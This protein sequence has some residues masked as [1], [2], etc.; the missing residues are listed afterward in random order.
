MSNTIR[1]I[2]IYGKG[3]I[4]KSTLS[5]NLT[6][7]FSQL[8]LQPAQIGCDPKADSVNTLMGGNF[9]STIS[10]IVREHGNSEE[11]IYKAIYRGFNDIV[12]IESGGPI[13]GQ[14]CAGRGVLVALNLI[15]Q[16]K[17]LEKLDID[18]AVYDVL[19]DI[20]CGGFAQPIRQGYAQ[21]VYIVT[22]GEYMALYAANN[23]AV[24][25]K[26]FA[27]QGL[28][29]R[30]AGIISNLRNVQYEKEII[31]EFAQLID[32]PIIHHIPRS[33]YVQKSELIGQTVIEAY[34]ESEQAKNYFE[35]A[36]KI[37]NNQER[38]IPNALSKQELLDLMKRYSNIDLNTV[39]HTI[40]SL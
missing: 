14:G 17:I 35:L 19:G 6:A 32:V 22:S 15:E 26:L 11:S 7:S 5:S 4:G 3:G 39:R 33:D 36:N 38:L 28:K 10:E 27:E 12:C 30:V 25:I 1:Q 37:L 23:I 29:S 8:Q 24:S 13:P 21:E 34:P 16:Y 31:E 18:I 40:S 2:A 9:I 20:V